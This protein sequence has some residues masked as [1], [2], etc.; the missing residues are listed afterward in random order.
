MSNMSTP[1]NYLDD[2]GGYDLA[3]LSRIAAT[4]KHEIIEKESRLKNGIEMLPFELDTILGDSMS[5][6]FLT[7]L[8]VT[9]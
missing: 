4:L 1:T 7:R 8:G 6:E 2:L 9:C 5:I 3:S